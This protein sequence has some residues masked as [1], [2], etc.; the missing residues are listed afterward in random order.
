[1]G[2]E[3]NAMLPVV[4]GLH[5][6]LRWAVILGAAYALF[7]M[8]RGWIGTGAWTRQDELASRLFTIVFDVQFLVGIFVAV[9]SPLIQIAIQSPDHIAAS[10]MIRFFAIEHVPVMVAAWII[11]HVTTVLVGRVD[12]P[13]KKHQRGA[14]GY[15]L[16][17]IMVLLAIPWWRPLLPGL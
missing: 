6:I 12:E 5:N 10:Q 2:Q 11:V 15:S 3:V 7:Q 1:M 8:Y 9:L 4:L 13:A 14:I 16:A 17:M